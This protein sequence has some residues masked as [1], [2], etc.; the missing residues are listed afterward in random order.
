ME[1]FL[2]STGIVAIA[3][4]GDKTQLL[5][6]LLAAKFRKPLPI[7]AGIFIATVA[8]HAGAAVIGS[9]IAALIGPDT[10]RWVLAAGFVAMGIW[11]LIPD[12]VDDD[13]ADKAPRFGVLLTTI[14]AFFLL[15]MGDK[16]QIATIALAAR[17]PEWWLVT[18]GTTFGM[19]IANV[20]AVLVGQ[21]ATQVL[22]LRVVHIVAALAF[23]VLGALLA[24]DGVPH[25]LG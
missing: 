13:E 15:E 3:E 7:I 11:V 10:M 19:M 24:L 18:L 9:W 2:V 12:K 20:P 1:S 4:I 21:A 23:F 5:A 22:P 6:L 14:I 8:N 16:T 25:L 17:Y